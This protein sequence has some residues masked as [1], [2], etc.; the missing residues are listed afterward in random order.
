MKSAAQGSPSKF[1]QIVVLQQ[2]ARALRNLWSAFCLLQELSKAPTH[3]EQGPER[4]PAMLK[5]ALIMPKSSCHPT[6]V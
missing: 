6:V 4:G 2:H 1:A 3:G 5:S